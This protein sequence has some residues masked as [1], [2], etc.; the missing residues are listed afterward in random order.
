[1]FSKS[2]FPFLGVVIGGV[3]GGIGGA[4]AG[5]FIAAILHGALRGLY[6]RLIQGRDESELDKL[7]REAGKNPEVAAKIYQLAA[8]KRMENVHSLYE[9]GVAMPSLSIEEQQSYIV[10]LEFMKNN[11]IQDGDKEQF[12]DFLHKV[13]TIHF[14]GNS[15]LGSHLRTIG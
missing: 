6:F 3:V 5:F 12:N 9:S 11:S 2:V 1:M 7:V 4:I 10:I 13:K 8:L 14:K 15:I